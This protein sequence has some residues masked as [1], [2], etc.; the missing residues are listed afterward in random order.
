MSVQ[1]KARDIKYVLFKHTGTGDLLTQDS[2]GD[3]HQRTDMA[4]DLNINCLNNELM[5]T[6][7]LHR[8]TIWLSNCQLKFIWNQ[9]IP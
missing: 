4:H 8:S 2:T 6:Y 1:L 3:A 9:S 5:T 7:I